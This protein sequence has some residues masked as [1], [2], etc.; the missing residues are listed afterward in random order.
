MWVNGKISDNNTEVLHA[1]TSDEF[2]ISTPA[3]GCDPIGV[4]M[5]YAPTLEDYQSARQTNPRCPACVT[6]LEE[7]KR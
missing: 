2:D 1:D 7:R 4:L 5:I 3:C 6:A